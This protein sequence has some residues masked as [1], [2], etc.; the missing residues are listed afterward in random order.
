MLIYYDTLANRAT[1]AS[2]PVFRLPVCLVARSNVTWKT[3]LIFLYFFEQIQLVLWAR[4]SKETIPGSY[5]P[6]MVARSHKCLEQQKRI[7]RFKTSQY[8]WSSLMCSSGNI[9]YMTFKLQLSAGPFSTPFN[10]RFFSEPPTFSRRKQYKLWLKQY[11]L[12]L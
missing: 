5:T 11:K 3:P 8:E 4:H 1:V 10:N 9:L 6:G 12:R 2:F 7:F